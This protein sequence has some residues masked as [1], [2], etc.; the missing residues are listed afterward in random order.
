[1]TQAALELPIACSGLPCFIRDYTLW[2]CDIFKT[3]TFFGQIKGRTTNTGA[4]STFSISSR[5]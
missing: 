3:P 2:P 1:M 5:A 4:F